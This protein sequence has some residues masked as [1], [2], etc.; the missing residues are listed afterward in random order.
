MNPQDHWKALPAH[1]KRAPL[2][3]WACALVWSAL[4]SFVAVGSFLDYCLAHGLGQGI[5]GLI[6]PVQALRLVPGFL[7]SAPGT[8]VLLASIAAAL[9]GAIV[10][11]IR[12]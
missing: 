7:L 10:Y 4:G 8:L 9:L 12:R 5:M 11:T 6:Y 1:G 3:V 2:L